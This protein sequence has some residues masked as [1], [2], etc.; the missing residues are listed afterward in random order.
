MQFG[1]HILAL[2]DCQAFQIRPVQGSFEQLPVEQ[3][4]SGRLDSDLVSLVFFIREFPYANVL[5][6]WVH[7]GRGGLV[8]LAYPDSGYKGTR[9]VIDRHKYF[10]CYR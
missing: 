7:P 4:K 9:L 1:Q 2:F 10:F 8:Y 5:R 3:G 6:Y